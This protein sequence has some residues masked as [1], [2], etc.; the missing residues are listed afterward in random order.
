MLAARVHHVTLPLNLIE[1]MFT[2]EYSYRTI[3]HF[4]EA[5][6]A[7]TTIVPPKSAARQVILTSF[8]IDFFKKK[9]Y[10]ISR[11]FVRSLPV[12]LC[13]QG[14]ARTTNSHR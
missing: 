9:D 12:I 1:A 3:T 2:H 14:A 5:L 7:L 4:E 8:L 11:T 6:A 13:C 10:F